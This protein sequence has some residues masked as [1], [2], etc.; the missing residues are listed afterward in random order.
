MFNKLLVISGPTA[1]G[2]TEIASKLAKKFNGELVSADSRQIYQGMDIGTGKDHPKDIPIHLID[3]IKPNQAFSVAQ[4]RQLALKIISDIQSS[5]KLPIVVGGTGQYID[6][7]FHY[8]DTFSIKP[9]HLLRFFLNKF[10]LSVLQFIYSHL[11]SQH[12]KLLNNS[13]VHNPHR[14]IRKIEIKLSSCLTPH[15]DVIARPGRSW[16]SL[17]L[18][19]TAPNSF[20]YSKINHRVENRLQDGLLVEIDH[21]LKH[22]SWRHPGL[23]TLAYKEFQS[24]YKNPN[25]PLEESIKKWKFDEHALVRR[26]KTW[27]NKDPQAIFIDITKENVYNHIENLVSKWYNIL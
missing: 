24:Y 25:Q 22:Y 5:G 7:L 27:F 4:Y 20:I 18:S 3:I 8:Q 21:L 11:D 17:H 16:Q 2:K 6:S 26:Q 10:P 1:T 19:L 9:N 13:D 15:Y 12:Y 23:N 14:L